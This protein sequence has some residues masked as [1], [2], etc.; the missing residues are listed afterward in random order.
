MEMSSR[1]LLLGLLVPLLVGQGCGMGMLQTARPT[2][3]GVIEAFAGSGAVANDVVKERTGN[4]AIWSVA[5]VGTRVGLT[6]H[7]DIGGKLQHFPGGLLEVKYNFLEPDN[8]LALSLRGGLGGSIGTMGAALHVPVSVGISYD[9]AYVAPYAHLGWSQFWFFKGEPEDAETVDY[10]DREGHGDGVLRATG[11]LR[12]IVN[13]YLSFY[14]EYN[15]WKPLLDYEG[16]FYRFDD[17]HAV[18]GGIAVCTG[19]PVF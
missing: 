13:K 12:I 5:E 8:P 3:R 9:W 2:P 1:F 19:D 7:L 17:T 16:D 18:L 15:Y 6:D 14:A 11:G 10:M 4:D